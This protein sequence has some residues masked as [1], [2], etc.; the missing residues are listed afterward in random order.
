MLPEQHPIFKSQPF[1]AGC[2][3]RFVCHSAKQDRKTVVV[4]KN[5]IKWCFPEHSEYHYANFS[6]IVNYHTAILNDLGTLLCLHNDQELQILSLE[7]ISSGD[8]L[9]EYK[10]SVPTGIKQVLW[11]P[12]GRLAS[13]IVVLSRNDEIC[14]YELLSDDIS[15][16]TGIWNSTSTSQKPGIDATVRDIVSMSFSND[17]MTLYVI[18]T[19]EGAD[20]YSIY[21]FLPS[22]IEVTEEQV[23]H[24]FHKALLQYNGL[25]EGDSSQLKRFVTKQLRFASQVRSL[26]QDQ[27]NNLE[28]A[29][30]L[31]LPI[32]NAFRMSVLQGPH[33]INPFPERLYDATAV[34]L[35]TLNLT[36]GTSE[37]LLISFDDGTILQCFRDSEPVMAWE[38]SNEALNNSLITLSASRIPGLI[39]TVSRTEFVVL[40]P[41]KATLVD[42]SNLTKA[43]NQSLLDCDIAVLLGADLSEQIHEQKGSFDSSSLWST[44]QDYVLL[45]SNATSH[46]V[47]PF[48]KRKPLLQE[49]GN[50]AALVQRRPYEQPITEL[51]ALNKRLQTLLKSPLSTAINSELRHRKLD[52]ASN[53]EQLSVLT[54]ISKEL[55]NRVMVAQTLALMLHTRLT[56]QQ[57]ELTSHLEKVCDVVSRKKAIDEKL[58]PQQERWKKVQNTNQ[59][60]KERFTTLQDKLKTISLSDE[61]TS[62]SISRTEMEW[63]LEVKNQVSKFNRLVCSQRDLNE[64]LSLLKLRSGYVDVDNTTTAE[65]MDT[66]SWEALREQLAK[67]ARIIA[68]CQ[69]QLENVSKELE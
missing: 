40:S 33:T 69:S 62:K 20:V 63:F 2:S 36:D 58:T 35:N 9:K 26:A 30:K 11:H 67:D 53:E 31:L 7:G 28:K 41:E 54:G 55:L 19:S 6:A 17:G 50:T 59:S 14:M 56:G 23:D 34:Q 47:I 45:S 4:E 24:S 32:S 25:T 49:A 37:I 46:F 61:L 8:S 29:T 66:A 52:D 42:V 44:E 39:S 57:R 18:N 1:E 51:L 43:I 12:N 64:T 13:C 10:F 48:T 22:E 5:S 27:S 68:E 16:P 15:V 38:C 60:I 65:A 3:K 21:P